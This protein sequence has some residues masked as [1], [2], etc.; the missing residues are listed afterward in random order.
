MKLFIIKNIIFLSI[1]TCLVAC[2]IYLTPPAIVDKD[3]F[4]AILID[5]HRIADS[6]KTPKIILVGGSNLSFGIDSK[7]LRKGLNLPTANMGL[8]AGVGLDFMLNQAKNVAKKNDVIFLSVEY[9]ISKGHYDLLQHTGS[10]FP[11]TKLFYQESLF[12]EVQEYIKTYQESYK[13]LVDKYLNKADKKSIT[14]TPNKINVYSRQ[15]ANED[16][17]VVAHLEE[18]A[19]EIVFSGIWKYKYWDEIATLNAFA[20]YAKENQIKVFFFFPTCSE[21]QFLSNKTTLLLLEKS[22]KEN[23]E[24]P[25]LNTP[26]QFVYPNSYFFDTNYHLNKIGRAKRTEDMINIVKKNE[27]VMEHLNYMQTLQ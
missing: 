13:N 5:K 27:K 12:L 16:A 9:F 20:K 21:K 11:K 24:I 23:L 25:I 26:E 7:M 10:I 17:D 6:I 4:M 18:P 19:R 1:I 14:K 3:S 2:L 15:A 22:L 8:H